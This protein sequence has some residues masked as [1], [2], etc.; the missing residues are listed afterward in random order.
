MQQEL[1]EN[2][3]KANQPISYEQFVDDIIYSSELGHDH[4]GYY[5][6]QITK[7]KNETIFGIKS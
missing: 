6:S 3:K 4:I 7:E 1:K 5:N 2:F